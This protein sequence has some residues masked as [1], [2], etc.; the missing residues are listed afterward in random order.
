MAA[1][2]SRHSRLT[3][4]EQRVGLG[5]GPDRRSRPDSQGRA[6]D[7]N[8]LR[9][10]VSALLTLTCLLCCSCSLAFDAS[11]KQCNTDADCAARGLTGSVCV[12]H[13]CQLQ[14]PAAGSGTMMS[15]VQGTGG[16]TGGRAAQATQPGAAG[17]VV[18]TAGR[19]SAA[20]GTSAASD[21]DGGMPG[22]G[23]TGA[24]G[25]T[26][27]NCAECSVDQDCEKRGVLGGM[28]VGAR[29]WAPKPECNAD[30][31][32]VSRGPEY[33]GGACLAMKCRPNP[34]WR[35]ESPP[36]TTQPTATNLTVPIVDALSLAMVPNVHLVAC[37]KL[38][39]MC[40]QPVAEATSG[41]DGNV[42]ITVP[43]SFAG[44]LQQ[45]ERRDFAPAMYFLPTTLPSNGMLPNFPLLASGAIINALATALG[46]GLDPTR[47]HM[48]L[49]A[50][51][52]FGMPQ[53]GVKF[54][55]PQADRSTVQF[56]VLDQLPSTTAKQT[57]AAG[58]GGYLNFPAGTA[59]ITATEVASSLELATVSVLVRAGFISVAYIR[60]MPRIQN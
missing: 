20:A 47:G 40:A 50:D 41:S 29:C 32:C 7:Q 51:D 59:L 31:D 2:M 27:Q 26:G 25:C 60:P 52:C 15:G 5:A 24:A 17:T 38:D 44:Y 56:Y 22:A 48:M 49:I 36:T 42:K 12:A 23:M 18:G 58:D 11:R 10:N 54:S 8:V 13:L 45:T 46:A 55:S 30:Q 16:V 1:C 43:A 53:A 39:L 28:C 37:N 9:V 33:V 3:E 34:K 35:C 4:I 21:D 19:T 14:T 6:L 57:P